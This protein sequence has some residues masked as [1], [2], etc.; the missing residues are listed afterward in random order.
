MFIPPSVGE[1]LPD[2]HP[3]WLVLDLVAELDLS[4]FHSRIGERWWRV[5]LSRQAFTDLSLPP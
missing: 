4:A 5:S 2:D 1:W 3:V